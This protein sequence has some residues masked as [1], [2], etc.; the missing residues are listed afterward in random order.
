[1]PI[2]C[3]LISTHSLSSEAE[4]NMVCNSSFAVE[5]G[6][7]FQTDIL[8][9]PLSYSSQGSAVI[10]SLII[11]PGPISHVPQ[12]RVQEGQFFIFF[13]DPIPHPCHVS[14]TTPSFPPSY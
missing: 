13:S 12:D 8:E 1:M 11:S 2:P 6:G 3:K 7:L 10:I 4:I 9:F 5:M 14:V